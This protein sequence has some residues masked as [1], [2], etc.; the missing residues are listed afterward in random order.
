MAFNLG[1]NFGFNIGFN[2]W[3]NIGFIIVLDIAFNIV[4]QYWDQYRV[5][6][7]VLILDLNNR[8]TIGL[9]IGSNMMFYM[10]IKSIED[11]IEYYHKQWVASNESNWF[12]GAGPIDH[13]NGLEGTNWDIKRTKVLRD[14]QKL[15]LFISNAFGIVE[16]WSMTEDS[17]LFC[18]K[19]C[20]LILI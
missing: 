20:S 11:F 10:S 2:I 19:K 1:F 3:F 4:V 15:G 5:Q 7:C 16:G 17:K 8:L 13:N 6:Y 9:N 18:D 14:K 12:V